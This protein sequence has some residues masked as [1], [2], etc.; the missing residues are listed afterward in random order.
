MNKNQVL[1]FQDEK[2]RDLH[3]W[4]IKLRHALEEAGFHVHPGI[5]TTI[6]TPGQYNHHCL[7]KGFNHRNWVN[8]YF[9]FIHSSTP[10]AYRK[11]LSTIRTKL[12]TL[13][14]CSN[15]EAVGREPWLVILPYLEDH[16]MTCK[17][18]ITMVSFR[19]L[20]RVVPL[21]NGLNGL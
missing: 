16:P 5:P 21:P 18:I 13:K 17:W 7:P 20:S 14:T 10:K 8:H 9:K 1:P 12:W 3:F 15:A 19:P 11:L 4:V 6:K 2:K